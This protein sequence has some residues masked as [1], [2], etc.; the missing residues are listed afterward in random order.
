MTATPPV[1]PRADGKPCDCYDLRI[2]G[3]DHSGSCIRHLDR[4]VQVT[5]DGA[6]CLLGSSADGMA[7]DVADGIGAPRHHVQTKAVR[8]DYV[9]G[10]AWVTV[11]IFAPYSAEV[12]R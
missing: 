7:A 4:W 2:A 12:A 10:G 6:E 9:S 3:A 11:E 1:Q 8:E 5:A